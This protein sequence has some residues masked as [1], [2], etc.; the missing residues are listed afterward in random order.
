[1]FRVDKSMVPLK[2]ANSKSISSFMHCFH[3]I[4]TSLISQA[5]L[6]A[7]L[8]EEPSDFIGSVFHYEFSKVTSHEAT[9]RQPPEEQPEESTP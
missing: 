5:L 1:M 7:V 8:D 4:L 6:Q 2:G 9:A 3:C